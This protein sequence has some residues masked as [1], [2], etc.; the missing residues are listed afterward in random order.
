MTSQEFQTAALAWV[1]ALAI[2]VPAGV[3]AVVKVLPG[4]EAL[5]AQIEEIKARLDRQ[6]ERQNQQ[7]RTVAQVALAAQPPNPPASQPPPH[8][9]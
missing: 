4:I 6:G 8:D 2:V 3:A 1:G 9:S 7:E 5:A